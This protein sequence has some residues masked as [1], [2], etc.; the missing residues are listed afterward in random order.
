MLLPF[1]LNARSAVTAL[2]G[3]SLIAQLFP[4][5]KLAQVLLLTLTLPA[6][7]V[8]VKSGLILLAIN[9]LSV[10]LSV[11]VPTAPFAVSVSGEPVTL[12]MA[13]GAVLVMFSVLLNGGL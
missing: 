2:P 8:P 4:G 5:D 13:M 9:T 1:I 11:N 6:S 7:N 3:L 10:F 12:M